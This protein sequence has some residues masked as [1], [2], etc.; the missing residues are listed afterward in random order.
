MNMIR[1]LSC[2][3][4]AGALVSVLG[5]PLSGSAQAS[6][7]RLFNQ[8]NK[9]VNAE[10]L[11]QS[12]SKH[13]LLAKASAVSTAAAN[14]PAPVPAPPASS[15]FSWTG[16]YVGMHAG[17]GS[18]NGDMTVTPL[19][20]AVTFI[21]LAPTT[22]SP[23]PS[24]GLWGGQAGYNWQSGHWVIGAEADISHSGM[25]GTQAVSPI[26][27]NNGTPFPGAGNNIT[28]HQDTDYFGTVRGRLG[29]TLVPR[30]LVYGT[31]GLAYGHVVYFANTDFLP[32][33]TE[34]YPAFADT[35]KTGWTA[36]GGAEVGIMTHFTAR[37]EYLFYDLGT[38]TITASPAPPLP[39]FAIRYDWN[40]S[41]HIVRVGFNFKF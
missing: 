19:P 34:I 5:W 28:S 26:I 31:G 2:W 10:E 27:Q 9:S 21:N 4:A 15:S 39:P 29:V 33:G 8:A 38:E 20:D 37:A 13:M 12:A 40:T 35:T 14:G 24:G 18:G 16:F 41:A 3:F 1:R 32:V 25:N 7:E 6:G 30:L 23:D 22:L 11:K 17:H 36:G